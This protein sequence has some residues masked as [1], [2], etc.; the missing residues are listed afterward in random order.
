MAVVID[1][2]HDEENPNAEGGEA[3]PD[4]LEDAK[5]LPMPKAPSQMIPS[6]R[7]PLDA[8]LIHATTT[9]YE[10]EEKGPQQGAPV[11]PLSCWQLSD[12]VRCS[13]SKCAL[14]M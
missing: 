8:E 2:I 13:P 3:L 7:P 11:Q 9:A 10:L 4:M 1:E 6:D 5:G 14:A 12:I